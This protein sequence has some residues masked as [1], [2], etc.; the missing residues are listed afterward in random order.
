MR[1]IIPLLAFFT[2]TLANPIQ[3][4][5][6]IAKRIFGVGEAEQANSFGYEGGETQTQAWMLAA[7]GKK[8]TYSFN[9]KSWVEPG[10]ATWPATNHQCFNETV[11]FDL[12]F[13]RYRCHNIKKINI[14]QRKGFLN[15]RKRKLVWSVAGPKNIEKYVHDNQGNPTHKWRNGRVDHLDPRSFELPSAETI[16]VTSQFLNNQPMKAGRVYWIQ[17]ETVEHPCQEIETPHNMN[18]KLVNC[19]EDGNEEETSDDD[20]DD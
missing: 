12:M 19:N 15:F 1:P 4:A 11:R 9:F 14:W 17:I 13:H 5:K 16:N 7:L 2:L 20:G 18:Y 10:I 3:K 6:G 8:G